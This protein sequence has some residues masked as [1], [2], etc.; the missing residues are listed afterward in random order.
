[1]LLK[2]MLSNMENL[3]FEP[4]TQNLDIL[5]FFFFPEKVTK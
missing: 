1:M 3:N 2:Y 4:L 5:D